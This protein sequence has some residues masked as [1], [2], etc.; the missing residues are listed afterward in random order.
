MWDE[1]PQTGLL[2]VYCY[3]LYSEHEYLNFF[4]KGALPTILEH[5]FVSLALHAATSGSDNQTIVL[6]RV[7][8]TSRCLEDSTQHDD[9]F[10]QTA[11]R[12]VESQ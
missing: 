10:Y 9:L 11:G 1:L 8:K 7:I 4:Q 2:N 3:K 6:R 5:F 12:I